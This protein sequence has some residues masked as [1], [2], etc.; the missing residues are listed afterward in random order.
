MN[1]DKKNKTGIF[2]GI[3]NMGNTCFLNAVLQCIT[4]T[5]PLVDCIKE[6]HTKTCM[7]DINCYFFILII[8]LNIK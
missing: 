3:E 1:M 8:H 6:N 5:G 2:A 4:A 7:C